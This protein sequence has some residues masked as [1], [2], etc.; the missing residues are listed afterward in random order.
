MSTKKLLRSESNSQRANVSCSSTTCVTVSAWM[1]SRAQRASV[2]MLR[3]KRRECAYMACGCDGLARCAAASR[4]VVDL[5]CCDA[6][7]RKAIMCSQPCT[8]SSCSAMDGSRL[9][10]NRSPFVTSAVM[11]LSM[12]R[13]SA[14]VILSLI[15]HRM[16]RSRWPGCASPAGPLARRGR[17][18]PHDALAA[19]R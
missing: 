1:N 15:W 14:W 8:S 12:S 16:R 3:L 6:G 11:I 18:L 7:A 10:S 5:Y 19:R 17:W 9:T 2:W 4:E 13:F